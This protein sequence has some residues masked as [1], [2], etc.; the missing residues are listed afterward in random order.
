MV[1][2][3]R[4][5]PKVPLLPE[6][7]AVPEGTPNQAGFSPNYEPEEIFEIAQKLARKV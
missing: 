7:A 4:A 6:G 5:I 2:R 1:R 3:L